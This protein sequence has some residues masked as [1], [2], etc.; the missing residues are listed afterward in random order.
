M[1]EPICPKTKGEHGIEIKKTETQIGRKIYTTTVAK[2]AYCK[3]VQWRT[4]DS[5][6]IQEREAVIIGEY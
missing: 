5:V 3:R 1:L 4:K 2:C 6:A